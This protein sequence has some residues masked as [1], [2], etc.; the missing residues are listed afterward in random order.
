MKRQLDDIGALTSTSPPPAKKSRADCDTCV[1]GRCGDC[2]TRVW[3]AAA[4]DRRLARPQAWMSYN[5]DV[6]TTRVI[7]GKKNPVECTLEIPAVG[8]IIGYYDG[9]YGNCSRDTYV[10]LRHCLTIG[11]WRK[12]VDGHRLV[13]ELILA[14][15]IKIDIGKGHEAAPDHPGEVSYATDTTYPLTLFYYP[16]DKE[17]RYRAEPE[18][19]AIYAPGVYYPMDI[20]IDK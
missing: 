16:S 12:D 15:V 4:V 9:G 1:D 3:V 7:Y 11:K 2:I 8:C 13:K 5:K 18:E 20:G 10:V 19:N 14:L 6:R 17:A